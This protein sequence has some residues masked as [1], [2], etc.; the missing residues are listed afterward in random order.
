MDHYE[1]LQR[2]VAERQD[3]PLH[4]TTTLLH[5]AI[6]TYA[7][8]KQRLQPYIP[9]NRFEISEFDIDGVP[10]ALMSAVLFYDLDF[11][12]VH[13]LPQVRDSFGQTNYRVYVKDRH[14]GEHCAWFFGTTLG[15]PIVHAISALWRI[16]WHS[17]HYKLD[18]RFDH[19][20]SRYSKYV[21]DIRSKWARAYVELEDTGEAAKI[22]PGFATADEMSLLLTHPVEGFYHRNDGLLGTYSIWHDALHLTLG[23][24]RTL[25]FGLFERLGLLSREEMAAPHSILMCPSTI[26][27]IH[28]PPRL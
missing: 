8:P 18:C 16:P 25:Y 12:Y 21:F 15:S 13:I 9:E 23:Q 17:A 2:R 24:P 26:F 6:V 27:R 3:G 20:N 1:I 5:F 22:L 28:L 10:L 4:A 19:E 11:H 7:I 14:S